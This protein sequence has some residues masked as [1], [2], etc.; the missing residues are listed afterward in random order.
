MLESLAAGLL[1]RFLGSYVEN[2]DPK[3]LNVGIWSGDVKLRNLKLRKES[4]D[5]LNLPIDVLFGFLGDLTLSVPWSNLKNEPVKIIIEDVYMLCAPGDI[6]NVD[7]EEQAERDFRVKLQKLARLE[8]INQSKHEAENESSKDVTFTQSLLT[9]IVD[10]LQVTIRNIHVRYEDMKCTFSEKPYTIGATLSEF[11]AISTDSNW[12]PSFISITQ[13]ITHKLMNLDSICVYW[14]TNSKSIL[15]DDQDV[16][17]SKLKG[18]IASGHDVPE[19]QFILRPV[20]GT[21]KLT[22]NKEGSTEEQAHIV[23]Q[24]FFDEFGVELDDTQYRELL[25]TMSKFHWYQKTLKYKRQRPPFSPSENPKGFLKYI[26]NCVLSEIHKKNYMSSWDYIKERRQKRNAYIELWKRKLRLVGPE[27]PL[28][29]QKDEEALLKLHKELTYDD[30]KFFRAL[31]RREYAKDKLKEESE[32]PEPAQRQ[33]NPGGWF[34]SWWGS[35]NQAS[36]DESALSITEEQKKELFDAIDFDENK[37]IMDSIDLPRDRVKMR[38]TN[39]LNK[40]SLVIKHSSKKFKL[41]EVVFEQCAAEFLQRPDSFLA[42]FELHEMRIEDGSPDTLYKHILSVSDHHNYHSAPNE[43]SASEPF[44]Q[45]VFENNPLD[46]SADTYLNI[47]LGSMLVFYHANYLNQLL[48]FF[49][50]PKKHWDTITAIMNAAEATVEGWTTQTRLGL[51]AL[52]E[53][54]KTLNLVFDASSPTFI[55][56]LNPHEWSSP[57]A[58]LDAGEMHMQSELV[59]KER[60]REI[61]NLSVEEYNKKSSN[62]LK[63][64]MFDRFHL[65]LKDTQFLIGPDIKSTISSLSVKRRDNQFCILDRMELQFIVDVSIFP[66]ALNLP[67][68]KTS[69]K[70]P[71]LNLYLNDYQYKIL[72]Q[73]VD[74]C[75]PNIDDSEEMG[76]DTP[77]DDEEF[78]FLDDF[79]KQRLS[80]REKD[81]ALLRQTERR[82]AQMTTTEINQSVFELDLKVDSAQ[83]SL[84]KCVDGATMKSQKLVQLYG[85]DLLLEF[86]NMAKE[87]HLDLHLNSLDLEDFID[88]SNVEE[89]KKLITS[90]NISSEE[91]KD[92]FQMSYHKT[93]R[94]VNYANTLIEVFDRDINLTMAALKFVLT[95]KSV[96]TLINYTLNTFTDPTA[97]L[98]EDVLRHNEPDTVDA[99]GKINMKLSMD[100][101]TVV[102]NDDSIQLATLELSA[103]ELILFILPESMK[104]SAKIGG[105]Q[106]TEKISE[107]LPPDS[108]FRQLISMHGDELVELV[109]ETFDPTNNPHE[110]TSKLDYKTGSMTVNVVEHS[111]HKIINYLAKFQKM[112]GLFDRARLA[113]YDQAG[114][115]DVV[116]NMKM[117]V[118]VN[119]PVIRFPK[120]VDPR[121]GKYDDVTFFLG[122]LFIENTFIKGGNGLINKIKTGIRRGKFTSLFHLENKT[123]QKLYMMDDLDLHFDIENDPN[124]KSNDPVFKIRG[125]FEPFSIKI[126]ELQLKFMYLLSTRL[127]ESFMID[128][129]K[130]TDDMEFAA[131]NASSVIGPNAQYKA[132]YDVF[133]VNKETAAPDPNGIFL[134]VAFDAPSVSLTLFNQTKNFQVVDNH[135]ITEIKLHDIGLKLHLTHESTL[136]AEVHIAAFT[137]EDIRT[138]KDNRHTM[139]IP[140]IDGNNYQFMGSLNR[141]TVDS[142][143]LLDLAITVDSPKVILAMDYLFALK[144]L[145]DNAFNVKKSS[146]IPET[147]ERRLSIDGNNTSVVP[148]TSTSSPSSTKL[149]YSIN[150]VNSQVIVLADPSKV[151]SEAVVFSVGQL[152][153]SDQNII[154]LSINNVGMFLCKMGSPTEDKIRLLDDCSSTL[155]I[156]NRGSTKSKLLTEIQ[157]S[158]GNM[159]MR[160]SLR[161]IRLAISIFNKA[162]GLAKDNGLISEKTEEEQATLATRYG[163]FSKDFKEKIKRY[164]PS[165]VSSVSDL[166]RDTNTYVPTS[167]VIL[168]AEN[169]DID[170]AGMRLVLI[171]DVHEL[172]I[173]DFNIKPFTIDAKDW[174]SNVDAVAT[175]ETYTNVF[176]Y[177]R[178]SWEPLIEAFPVT[179]HAT[180]GGDKDAS[181]LFEIVSNKVAE[182]TLSTRT[183]ALLSNISD[184][185]F[186]STDTNLIARGAEKPYKVFNDTGLDVNI[187]IRDDNSSDG[188]RQ[189]TTLPYTAT[190]PWEFEDWRAVRESLDTDNSKNILHVELCDS[191]YNTI[192]DV[193]AT[194]EGET[195]HKLYPT[196]NDVHNRLVTDLKLCENNVKLIT[197]RSSLLIENSTYTKLQIR[198]GSN[199]QNVLIIEPSEK[200]SIPIDA[201]Y[202]SRIFVRPSNGSKYRWSNSVIY[203]DYLIKRGPQALYCEAIESE[204]TFHLEAEARYHY[205]EQLSKAYPHMTV[206]VSSPLIIENLLP[207]DMSFLLFSRNTRSKNPK[208]L[209][210]GEKVPIHDISLEDFLLFAV[211]PVNEGFKWSNEII[212]NSPRNA[213]IKPENKVQLKHDSGQKVNLKLHYHKIEGM[214]AKLISVYSPYVILNK[215]ERD[216][217]IEG[218]RQCGIM[219][220]PAYIKDGKRFSKPKIFSFDRDDRNKNRARIRFRD[221]APSIPTSFE[222][223]G[224]AVDVSMDIPNKDKECNIG[225]Y[226]TEGSGKYSLSKVVEIQ[227]RYVIRN[228]FDVDIMITESEFTDGVSTLTPGSSAP[229]YKLRN[230]VN[231]QL[232]VKFLGSDSVWSQP[233]MIKDVGTTYLKVLK[234]SS[235]QILLRVDIY[236]DNATLFV[237]LSDANDKWPFSVRNFSD[238]EF[239]FWQRD[240]RII[241]ED[242]DD[243]DYRSDYDSRGYAPLY[244]RVPP[245]SV[246]PYAWDYP[247][248]RQKKLVIHAKNRRREIDLNELGNLK[249]M[250]LPGASKSDPPLIVDFN[251]VMDNG[252]QALVITNYNEELSL[253]KLRHHQSTS[254]SLSGSTNNEPFEVNDSDNEIKMRVSV[255]FQGVGI[256]LINTS[257]LQELLYISMKGLELRYN[258]SEI[259]QTLTWKLKWIQVDNQLF[260]GIY[261]NILYP[262]RIPNTTKEINVHPAL[263]GSISKVKDSTH[264]SLNF[265]F[266]TVLLQEMTLQL[267]EDFLFALI[268]F[269]K[270][271]GA[272]W[273][274]AIPDELCSELCELSEPTKTQSDLDVYFEMLHIQPT[275][276]H[277]SFVRTERVN[278]DEEEKKAQGTSTLMFFLNVLTMALG[279][280]NSAPIKMSSLMMENVRV[281][282]PALLEVIQAH[283]GQQFFYQLHKILGSADFL[284]NPVGLFN[285]I[286]SGV[287]DLFYEPYQ[288][289]I[290]NDRP[291]ELGISLAKGGLSFM[292][293]SV[294]GLS[295]SFSRL[296]GSMAKG[297]SVATRDSEFQGRRRLQQRQRGAVGFAA[298]AS[299]FMNTIGSGITGV[300]LDPYKGASKEGATGFLKGLGKGII[301]L[302]TKTAIGVLDLASN[303]S[304]GIRNTTTMM[305][306]G[307]IDRVRLP[308]YVGLVEV[309]KPYNAREAQG[310]FWL[311]TANGGQF[312]SDQYVGHLVLRREGNVVLVSLSHILRISLSTREVLEQANFT[313]VGGVRLSKNGLHVVLRTPPNHQL[314]FACTD[315]EERRYLYKTVAVAV[316]E[317]NQRYDT[318]L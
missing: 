100:G 133:K 259:Y 154:S 103:A 239:I 120:F 117:N 233:F 194:E 93:Q 170:F 175:I 140:K 71:N 260:G 221:S 31:A 5:A 81:V 43:V 77:N 68:V 180:K 178:S 160:L 80:D 130:E 113:A 52:L 128:E 187:W 125:Y 245:R 255:A 38:I 257:R 101:V 308:R 19:H 206:V 156:D 249:P 263:S 182:I 193:D 127:A 264:S 84:Q 169:M 232:S 49:N 95:P 144:S 55:V 253:Y 274:R 73:L 98:P 131:I 50:P 85:N 13:R 3:Q 41:C 62:Q 300:A 166:S 18:S 30:I 167:E 191:N 278:A 83:L 258:N 238:H 7:T 72:M 115:L 214:R 54:H 307:T 32:S 269:F 51:Q 88:D 45:V 22:L 267:D 46:E 91:T 283:Y 146:T 114:T 35:S 272:S 301:G 65:F 139:L 44:F 24:L 119:A 10:N 312:Q 86:K 57:C 268:D 227:P 129:I 309:I 192:I 229:L 183:I 250:R 310:Q 230:F 56:P 60:I 288:G 148:L 177:S 107:D 106:L 282:M 111:L 75:I 291:Q 159:V 161:D 23:A 277:L 40:G 295:D 273:Q 176:N 306:G 242:E 163:R 212:I 36:T 215:T 155:I 224:Q 94:I 121:S 204:T 317:F 305:D 318:E 251:I 284:G 276:L 136:K 211:Q 33:T 37:E 4:L 222:A 186:T 270:I 141:Y 185:L 190:I 12:K 16:M 104:A 208:L 281:S 90:Y 256:S 53:E 150:I 26:A 132:S 89:F 78:L 149:Q 126:T 298:S 189:L 315:T 225:I 302:P 152:L 286:S 87:M 293:K 290:M 248:G 297:L 8:M 145:F 27:N 171:G 184:S 105:L 289:Y 96:L 64:L 9:K 210:K 218:D 20:S 1:N 216:L 213:E 134:D 262:T 122:Q 313:D 311:K 202:N 237:E 316:S 271:P 66:K 29:D 285:T 135:G 209:K 2:F 303:V 137:V 168:K 58:V 116:N 254:S 246:M 235:G 151:D 74:K 294:F 240:P 63:R 28:P 247:S 69:G 47:K 199:E 220:S 59:P 123:T 112:K 61:T 198:I 124:A 108:I 17:I 174:S 138:S 21:G 314:F 219:H 14:N 188:R 243:L 143:E 15:D 173:L 236:L 223:I 265:K 205:R 195:L 244:Y 261:Q 181:F 142:T 153:L 200:R 266:A 42:K 92:L 296:T 99:P 39:L 158:I 304:E 217:Y 207:Y 231:K 76:D 197:L 82:L 179:F 226:V 97:E 102:L 164:A 299:S 70:L 110:Y 241:D 287:K 201:V 48:R 25:H 165:I 67:R 172:P 11:S 118:L 34:S 147:N 252:V 157:G 162:M 228:R 275:L 279:N 234:Q 6:V 280:V 109:Y 79:R 203:W 196:V 292:K